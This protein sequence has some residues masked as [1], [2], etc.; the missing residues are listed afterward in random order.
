VTS[1]PAGINCG[2]GSTACT[3]SFASG[4]LVTL[5][6]AAASGYAFSGWS[7]ACSGTTASCAVTMS[8]AQS[9]GATFAA[10]SSS[11]AHYLIS[12]AYPLADQQP[13]HFDVACDSGAWVTSPPAVNPDGTS[14]LHFDV[15]SLASG[16]HSCSVTAA[17]ASN[18]Q[19]SAVTASFTL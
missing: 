7:G 3:Q 10:S 18:Q 2:A 5:T 12:D 6:A 1:S 14:Y 17:N 4:A 19:T 13:N 9:A 16:S 8:T 15:S 11:T